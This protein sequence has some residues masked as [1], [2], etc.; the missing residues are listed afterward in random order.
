M[1][2]VGDGRG[3]LRG[4]LGAAARG[5][6]LGRGGEQDPHR[7]VGRDD[8]GD[9]AALDDD[10]G[11]TGCRDQRAEQRVHATRAPRARARRR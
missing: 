9:V 2:R 11:A 6:H 1:Q 4:Q 5:A 10:A 3:I 7:R 8:G